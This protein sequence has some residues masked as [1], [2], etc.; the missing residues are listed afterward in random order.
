MY[1]IRH[2]RLA[3]VGSPIPAELRQLNELTL[4]M[5]R[6]IFHTVKTEMPM[7]LKAAGS[8]L[9]AVVPNGKKLH[10]TFDTVVLPDS[11][12]AITVLTH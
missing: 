8:F 9:T 11:F 4:Q 12:T 2:D 5:H 10:S 1:V 3:R 6:S 7:C